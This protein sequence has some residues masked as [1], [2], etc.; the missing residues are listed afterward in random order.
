MEVF[1]APVDAS[2]RPVMSA[3]RAAAGRFFV[4]A[5]HRTKLAKINNKKSQ[6]FC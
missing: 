2:F 4:L 3:F 6:K 1:G 5:L